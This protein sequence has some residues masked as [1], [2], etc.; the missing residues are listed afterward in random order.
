MEMAACRHKRTLLILIITVH[1][2]QVWAQILDQAT[3]INNSSST[4]HSNR[5][6]VV[7]FRAQQQNFAANETIDFVSHVLIAS[8]LTVALIGMLS[9]VIYVLDFHLR[10]SRRY[11]V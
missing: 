8:I 5:S 1:F 9:Y 2:D 11:T 4:V 10:V 6:Q 3:A 7:A